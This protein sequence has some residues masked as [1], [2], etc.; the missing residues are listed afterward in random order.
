MGYLAEFLYIGVVV[1][2][3]AFLGRRFSLPHG[4]TRKLIH[5]LICFVYVLEYIFFRGQWQS[6]IVP[7][8]VTILLFFTARYALV[9]SMVNPKNPYGIFFY[10]VAVTAVMALS[11]LSP[12]FLL[13]GGAAIFCLSFGDGFAALLGELV[14]RPHRLIGNKSVE[15]CLFCFAFSLLGLCLLGLLI[16]EAMLTLPA[17]LIAA[18]VTVLL[19]L[20]GGRFDNL[21][22]TF[23]VTLTVR[24]LAA[25]EVAYA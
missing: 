5:I 1:G 25:W 7:A 21:F 9:P 15:G 8:V 24:L 14:R 16:P 18:A 6:L 11:L 4:V 12:A 22:I 2:L 17:A 10:A 20:F 3:L 13:P 23:G 19:E